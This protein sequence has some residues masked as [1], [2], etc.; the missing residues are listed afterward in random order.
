MNPVGR[1]LRTMCTAIAVV[2]ALPALA[3]PSNVAVVPPN[4][5]RFLER[6]RFDIRVEGAGTGPF[7][8]TLVVDGVPVAFSSGEQN[9]MATD[10]ITSTGWGGFNVRGYSIGEPGL[11]TLTATFTDATG[12]VSASSTIQVLGI[13][14]K[15]SGHEAGGV[16]N[17]IIMLGDGMGV[18]HR[19]AARIVKFGVSHG[20][21]NGRLEME[22]F[23]GTGLVSTHSLNSIITDSAP[24]MACYSTGSH[25]NNNQEG[26][27]PAHVTSPFY[28]PRVE[29]MSEYLRR[30]KST[31][32]GIVTTADIE[33]ATPAAN[34]VHTGNRNAGTGI[35]DQ[36]LDESGNSGLAVLMGGGRRWFLPSTQY[37][38]SRA[39]STD[40]AGLPS[41]LLAGW[42]LPAAAAGV[43]DPTRDLVADFRAAGF[44]YADDATSLSSLKSHPPKKLLGLFGYGNMNAALDKIAK[45]RAT[46]LPDGTYVVDHYRAPNQPM[47]DEMTEVALSVLSKNRKGF[48]LMVEGAHIDKQ[49]HLMD[50]DRVIGETIEFDNA[51]GVVRRFAEKAGNTV[52]VVLADHECAGFSLIGALSGG[53][54]AAKALPSDAATLDPSKTPARQAAVGTYDLA[55]FPRY[56]IQTDGYPATM[57]VDG[58]VLVGYGASGD[59]FETWLSKPL[60]VVDSLLPDSIKAELKAKGYGS[61]PAQRA[62]DANG[63]FLRGHVTGGQAVHTAADIPISAF[64]TGSDV[65]KEF[66][67]VQ[68]NTD[69]FFKLMRAALVPGDGGHHECDSRD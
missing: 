7:Q 25:A 61:E 15:R 67:G 43:S 38:S 11:H 63:F 45:R 19:T 17:V 54:A 34:V 40:Y 8:A 18:A 33:D 3:A 4:G 36:Y 52:V 27:Y 21:P 53:V 23:P 44:A 29:Y 62:S 66:V 58:K 46:P 59:R 5:A 9:T 12:T 13:H 55:G 26:V 68:K 22:G 65:W 47:L 28:Q 42:G 57:D 48:V 39:A 50:A 49:S 69:V 1:S 56:A 31:S 24:G 20:D 14:G 37:G 2:L 32:L 35:C 6:Q 64:S 60:P 41:D 10:G 51:V 16:K 30:V